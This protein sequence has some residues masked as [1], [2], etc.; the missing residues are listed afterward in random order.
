MLDHM[1][2]VALCFTCRN[3][4]EDTGLV[5]FLISHHIGS[6]A[7]KRAKVHVRMGG[8]GDHAVAQGGDVAGGRQQGRGQGVVEG[9][10]ECI[11][12]RIALYTAAHRH[13][14]IL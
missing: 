3:D 9:P 13:C 2:L 10:G 4:V 14:L 7:K 8:I 11:S 1:G 6:P 12:R 5:C